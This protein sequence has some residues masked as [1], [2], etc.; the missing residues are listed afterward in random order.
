MPDYYTQSGAPAQ[1]SAGLSATLRS[2]FALIAAGFA[3]LP[4]LS[5]NA[6]K[7]VVVNGGA[8]GLTVTTSAL[9]LSGDLTKA[10]SDALTLTTTGVTNVT[11]PTTGT[12]A[13]R[14]GT[15]TLTNK[16][17]T[18]PVLSGSVTGT[19]TLAGTP[20]ITSP[21]ISAPVLSGSVTGTYT[22]AG[23]PTI[24][25]PTLSGSVSGTYTLAGTPTIA[26]PT[27]T[28]TATFSGLID[29]SGASAGQIKFPATQN[30][31]SNVNTLDDYEE[32]TWTPSLGG[33][34]TYTQ[35]NGTYTK[36]GR[37]VFIQGDLTVNILGTG[38]S[39]EITGLPFTSANSGVQFPGSASFTSSV[40][41]LVFLMCQVQQNATK[42]IFPN[43]TAAAS[44]VGTAGVFR[45]GTAISV[46]VAYMV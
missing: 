19:Y 33:T 14:A 7:I 38:S 40:T 44:S 4:S 11:F 23:T 37:M 16:T 12:L 35:R 21:T 10:G 18:A 27:I 31:S 6:N 32:G 30:P 17:I 34:A 9:V 1:R 13:T 26:A 39:T 29:A 15:E 2:E 36:I 5:G 41:N 22:L 3:K 45:N 28:G 42:I 25:S 20:T 24:S 8:T 43:L 46:A